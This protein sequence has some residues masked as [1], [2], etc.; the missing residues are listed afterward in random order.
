MYKGEEEIIERMR[1][2]LTQRCDQYKVWRTFYMFDIN[3]FHLLIFYKW[4]LILLLVNMVVIH[5]S[6]YDAP[7]WCPPH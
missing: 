1:E 3:D 2:L 6:I 7:C 4:I 5:H